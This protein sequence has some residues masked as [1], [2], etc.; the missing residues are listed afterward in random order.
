LERVSLFRGYPEKLRVD[1]GPEFI[2]LALADW[3]EENNVMLDFIQPGKPTQNSYIERFNRT[4]RDE[5]LDLYLFR[6][7][8]EVRQ[9]TEEWM[10][11]YNNERPHDSLND[12]TSVEFL[13]ANNQ[14][15]NSNPAWN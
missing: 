13:Q 7:L 10:V 14:P 12:M 5:L 1:N 8:R 6:T 3:A 9:M 2:S 4:Y 11:R 15:G